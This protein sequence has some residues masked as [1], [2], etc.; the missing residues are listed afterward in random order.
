MGVRQPVRIS[1]GHGYGSPEATAAGEYPRGP[2]AVL[3]LLLLFVGLAVATVW[4]VAIPAFNRAP[5]VERSCEVI[6]L[7]SGTTK[8]I[9]E[10]TRASRAAT[11]KP[12]RHAKH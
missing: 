3:P 2:S 9:R 11:N 12:A 1:P 6:V 7:K 4:F 10:P 8:C 5:H